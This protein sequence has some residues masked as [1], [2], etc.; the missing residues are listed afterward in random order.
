MI[1]LVQKILWEIKCN[2]LKIPFLKKLFQSYFSELTD[3]PI[4]IDKRRSWQTIENIK[5]Y[6]EIF[7]KKPKI[8]CTVRNL[9][10][11]IASYKSLYLQNNKKWDTKF[12]TGNRFENDFSS[13]KYTWNSE[14]KDCLLL[15]EYDD[16][17]K[18]T[19]KTINKIYDF[20]E[21]PYFKHNLKKHCF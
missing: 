8:I 21:Q 5:M 9:E 11:I 14:F 17:V 18:N 3:K 2:R 19:Q 10:E 16:L 12:L 15:I 6:K 20:I 7:G 4:V 13:L 1:N